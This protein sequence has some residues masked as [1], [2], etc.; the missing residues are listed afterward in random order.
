[1]LDR[2]QVGQSAI[3]RNKAGRRADD[4]CELLPQ[5]RP[6]LRIESANPCLAAQPSIVKPDRDVG[7][8]GKPAQPFCQFPGWLRAT[9]YSE[10]KTMQC[11]SGLP[12]NS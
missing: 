2:V 5:L 11:A 9:I 6:V 8:L 12:P 10:L 7:P 1:M 3:G 4:L